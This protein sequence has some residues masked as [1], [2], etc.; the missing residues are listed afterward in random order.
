MKIV[1]TKVILSIAIG[2]IIGLLIGKFYE[3]TTTNYHFK[4]HEIS[5]G[6]YQNNFKGNNRVVIKSKTN[7]DFDNALFYG[8]VATGVSL[9]IF[10]IP[11]LL[12]NKNN[13]N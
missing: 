3:S 9:L 2:L 5:E 6:D 12:K 13:L 7:F 1:I 4:G 10:F 11:M 8:G